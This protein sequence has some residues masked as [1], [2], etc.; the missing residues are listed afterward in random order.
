MLSA[1]LPA[2]AMLVG[3]VTRCLPL[4][5]LVV[6]CAAS[7]PVEE[8]AQRTRAMLDAK[9]YAGA[10]LESSRALDNL[11]DL[12]NVSMLRG[13]AL[14]LPLLD[15]LM[16]E[17]GAGAKDRLNFKEAYDAFRLAVVMDPKNAE[18]AEELESLTLLLRSLEDGSLDGDDTSVETG[19]SD[20]SMAAKV[21]K[22]EEVGDAVDVAAEQEVDLDVVIVGAGAAGIGQAVSLIFTFGLDSSRVQILER[23]EEIGTSFR[24]WPKEMRF[25]SPSFNQAGWTS[26]FDLNSVAH[27]SSPAFSLHAEHPSGTQYADYLVQLSELAKLDVQLRTEVVK[28]EPVDGVYDVH[29]R[30][31]G[32]DGV[33]EEKT[34]RTRFVVWAAGEF[35]YPKETSDDVTGLELCTHNSRVRSWA[36]HPGDDIVVIGGYESGVDAAIN[37]AKAGKQCTV[38]ASSP[39][40]N[41]VSPEP[42]VELSPYTADRLRDVT[43]ASFSP[44]PKL[45]APL[46][47]HKVEKAPEGGFNVIAKTNGDW[48]AAENQMP[49][50]SLR[51]TFAW[52][53]G[54]EDDAVVVHTP[55]PPV[56]CTGFDGSVSFMARNLFDLADD[57]MEKKGCLVGA[58]LLTDE[59]ESTKSP[60]VFLVGPTVSHGELSFC[61][62]YKFRQRF[63]IVSDAI[64]RRLGRDTTDAVEEARRT[65]MFLDDLSCCKGACGEAC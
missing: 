31:T 63:G 42:S 58:P 53:G 25:I 19:E 9:D 23:G 6:A 33:Q 10:A 35:Q 13:R 34:M 48:N 3:A 59:D 43:A 46:R 7:G 54:S 44:S 16:S 49:P 64:C 21:V 24:M 20:P 55:Q 2:V 15:E 47:V 29:L 4:R 36:S 38:I 12:S 41:A 56:L 37:L 30:T 8:Y 62:I 40:W 22:G 14:L 51:N 60:G 32:A 52:R 27:G 1:A 18:A 28:V 17:G 61:F 39:T 57:S 45:M 50:G 5:A 65:N 26:S 11:P